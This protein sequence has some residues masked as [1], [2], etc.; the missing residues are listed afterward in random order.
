[1][2]DHELHISKRLKALLPPLTKEERK[3]LEA[4]L[5]ADGRVIDPILFWYDGTKKFIVDGMHRYQIATKNALPY[6]SDRVEIDGGMED[7]EIWILDHQLGRRNLLSPQAIRKAR[8]D[9]YNRMKRKDGGHGDHA[10]QRGRPECQND[11]PVGDAAEKIGAKAGVSPS[12]IKRDGRRADTLEGCS[13]VIQRAVGSGTLKASDADLKSLSKLTAGDQQTIATTIRKGR[14]KSVKEAMKLDGIKAPAA[15]P[16]KPKPPKKFDK[17]AY[18]K[19]WEQAIGPVVRLVDKIADGV[20]E[21][22]SE[23]HV[24]VQE[25]LEHASR[26]MAAWMGVK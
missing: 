21:K 23:D 1:M 25:A 3:Q 14:A 9:L 7:V 18:F 15:K 26:N 20:G 16:A 10:P 2:T 6:T 24:C 5:V 17:A 4:N 11:T 12:T 22:G 13:P 19:Q 8:G